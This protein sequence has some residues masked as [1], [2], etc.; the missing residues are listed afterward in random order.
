MAGQGQGS[1]FA[2]SWVRVGQRVVEV[3]D[4]E[5]PD[6]SHT[7]QE[8]EAAARAANKE[9]ASRRLVMRR[10]GTN[11]VLVGDKNTVRIYG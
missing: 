8:R 7:S 3:A 4:T 2:S 1:A 6:T 11:E 5:L 9:C 10:P